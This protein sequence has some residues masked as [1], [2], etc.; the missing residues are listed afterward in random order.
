MVRNNQSRLIASVKKLNIGVIN[1][2]TIRAGQVR[3]SEIRN[4]GL[5]KKV[6]DMR[7]LAV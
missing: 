1:K 6:A 3:K 5:T 2:Y 4:C 7:T